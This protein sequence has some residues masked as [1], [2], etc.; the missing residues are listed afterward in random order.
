MLPSDL[1]DIV[2]RM[3][4]KNVDRRYESAAA[5][6]A[7]LRSVAAMLDVRDGSAEPPTLALPKRRR[8]GPWIAF[9]IAAAVIVAL[10]LTATGVADPWLAAIARTWRSL[11]GLQLHAR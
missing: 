10:L 7:E 3:L 2:L 5:L 8:T 9:V 11:A 1:D 4:D 6:A